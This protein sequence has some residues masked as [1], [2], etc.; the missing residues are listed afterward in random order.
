MTTVTTLPYG[1]TRADL[2]AAFNGNE[3]II[4][5]F[6]K[7]IQSVANSATASTAAVAA[8]D[9]LQDATALLLSPNAAFGN[10]RILALA[11][12]LAFTDGGPGEE[13]TI[14]L[15]IPLTFNGDHALVINLIADTNVTFPPIGRLMGSGAE[16]PSYANDATA[17]AAGF[18]VGD[19]YKQPLGVVAWRQV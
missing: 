13:F 14:G 6:E 12:P 10:E 7:V 17:A 11:S 3:K 16:A 4:R 5:A 15:T 8:T 19:I 9:A 1:I 18:E 2:A